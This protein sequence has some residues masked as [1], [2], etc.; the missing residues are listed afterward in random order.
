MITDLKPST[1]HMTSL[2]R[3]SSL[4]CYRSVFIGWSNHTAVWDRLIDGQLFIYL[5]QWSQTLKVFLIQKCYFRTYCTSNNLCDVNSDIIKQILRPPTAVGSTV[6]YSICR[7]P[8]QTCQMSGSYFA[9]TLVTLNGS[10]V[11]CSDPWPGALF[12]WTCLIS[13]CSALKAPP[14]SFCLTESITRRKVW[15]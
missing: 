10:E 11:K 4:T 5:F 8:E 2:R 15:W 6:Y 3:C 1:E 7:V 13:T 12:N 9:R 14:S